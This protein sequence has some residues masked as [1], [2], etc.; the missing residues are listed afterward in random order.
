MEKATTA[1]EVKLP[2]EI[3]TLTHLRSNDGKPVQVICEPIERLAVAAIVRSLPG[4]RVQAMRN[5]AAEPEKADPEVLLERIKTFEQYGPRLIELGA[6]L[7]DGAGGRIR[8]AFYFGSSRPVLWPENEPW[9][10]PQS[11]PGRLLQF[12]DKQLLVGSI[13]RQSGYLEEEAAEGG[14]TF[15]DENGV[16]RSDRLGAVEAGEGSRP[17]PVGSAS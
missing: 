4:E 2:I 8:P 1:S 16:G 17:D 12:E 9:P 3:V 7:D 11:V 14:A 10:H 6:A 5:A 15:P 13:M